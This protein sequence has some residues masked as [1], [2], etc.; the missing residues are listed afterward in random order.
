MDF[1]LE[2]MKL[3]VY[4]ALDSFKG[5]VLNQL[6]RM[7]FSK[8]WIGS[9]L[10]DLTFI[11]ENAFCQGLQLT[12]KIMKAP[13]HIVREILELCLEVGNLRFLCLG[14][15]GNTDLRAIVRPLFTIILL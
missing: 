10:A 15:R 3:P 9:Q 14:L 13:V 7:K 1:G 8:H 2:L 4:D 6:G 5:E 11:I 12:L